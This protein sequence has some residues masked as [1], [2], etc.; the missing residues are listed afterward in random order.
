MIITP[1]VEINSFTRGFAWLSL[2][3]FLY[4]LRGVPLGDGGC[5]EAPRSGGYEFRY[6]N[7][8][9]V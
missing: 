8:R 1:V 3:Q 5:C 9:E 7:L 2:W 4:T 6:H